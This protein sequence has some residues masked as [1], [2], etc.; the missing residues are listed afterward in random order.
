[1][2]LELDPLRVSPVLPGLVPWGVFCQEFVK[3]CVGQLCLGFLYVCHLDHDNSFT[4]LINFLYKNIQV[5]SKVENGFV[6]HR[7]EVVT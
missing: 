3:L 6:L 7:T 5:V 1:M 4:L 2:F